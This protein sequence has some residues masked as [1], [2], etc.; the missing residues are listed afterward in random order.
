MAG[1]TKLIE[2]I[3]LK[4]VYPRQEISEF[5]CYKAFT[6][7][8]NNIYLYLDPTECAL[9]SFLVGFSDAACIITY[10]TTLLKQFDKASDRA[11]EIYGVDK[12]KYRTSRDNARMAFIS[13]VEK[14]LLIRISGKNRFM[15]NPYVVYNGNSTRFHRKN[16]HQEY[17]E[18][19]NGADVA[20]KLT[21]Y[22]N[23]IEKEFKRKT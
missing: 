12:I 3:T 14:G 6:R 11:K 19:V 16:R 10:S 21:E 1:N 20:N 15:I 17:L 9:F 22:C 13:L 5:S 23:N 2:S 4:E 7:H 18:I 8:W